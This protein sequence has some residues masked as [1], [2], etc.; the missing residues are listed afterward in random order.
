MK[1]K[2]TNKHVWGTV[3]IYGFMFLFEL[4]RFI[5]LSAYFSCKF[6]YIHTYIHVY[7]NVVASVCIKACK[8]LATFSRCIWKGE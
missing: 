1:S 6:R 2:Q 8:K 4:A 5:I 3:C 7:N